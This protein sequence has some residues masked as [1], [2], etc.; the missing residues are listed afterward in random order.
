MKYIKYLIAASSLLFVLLFVSNKLM[1]KGGG[2]YITPKPSET[3]LVEEGQKLG[4]KEEW[5]EQMHRSAPDVDWQKKDFDFRLERANTEKRF[6]SRENEIYGQWAEVGSNNQAG[7]TLVAE[8]DLEESIVYVASDG[9]Q[10]WKGGLGTGNW[11]SITDHFRIPAINFIRNIHEENLDRLLIGAGVWGV[12]GIMFSD[13]GGSTWEQATGLDGIADWGYIRRVVMKNDPHEGIFL[14]SQEWDYDLWQAMSSI[15]VSYDLGESFEFLQSFP[16]G[17]NQTDIWTDRYSNGNV[18]VLDINK[19]Y[20]LTNDGNLDYIGEVATDEPER[21]YLVG[22]KEDENLSFYAM[23]YTSSLSSFYASFD[24]GE[25]WGLK[26]SLD[27][28]PFMTGSFAASPVTP[29]LLYF[30]GVDAYTSPDHGETW[31]KINSWGDYYGDPEGKL[32]ADIPSFN[33][34]INS[35]DDEI[36][37]IN[38]DGGIYLSLDD[39]ES[40]LNLSLNNLRISQYYSSYTC[41]FAPQNT[42]AGA[43]DQGYQFSDEGGA[44]EVL[45][46][47]QVI[48]G[49]YGHIVSGDEGASVWMVYPGFAMY[50]PDANSN[51]PL[52]FW[53][54]VGSNYQWMPELMADPNDP[55][56]VYIAGGN[57]SSGA[58]QIH[59]TYSNSQMTYAEEPFDFS[60]G[61]G[62]NISAMAYSTL[63]SDFRYVMTTELDFFYSVDGGDS[64][65]QTEGFD[66]PGSHYFYGADIEPSK[67]TL[68]LIYIG[69]SGYSSPGVFV[70]DD[71]GLTFSDYSEGLPETLIHDLALSADDSLLFAATEVGAYVCK[72]SEGIWYDLNDDMLPD[73]NF[74]AVDFVESLNVARFASYG[75]GIWDFDL[76]PDVVADFAADPELVEQEG[77]VQFTNLSMW[78]PTSYEW[79]FEGGTPETSDLENPGVV[80]FEPGI[81]D[82]KLIVHNNNSSDTLIKTDYIEVLPFTGIVGGETKAE[83]V[84]FPNPANEVVHIKSDIFIEQ[85]ILLDL[86]GRQLRE[87]IPGTNGLSI[88][89]KAFSKGAYIIKVK[90]EN[91]I[92]TKKIIRK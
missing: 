23:L 16:H 81:F 34:F 67:N 77:S 33:S 66:S 3:I 5:L 42:H 45:D 72:T 9:G 29:G 31:D 68:G 87:F 85:V 52:R 25:N 32:H 13:D 91:G 56:S 51:G 53:N 60:N 19:I 39:A 26:G 50:R 59:L 70:S 63:N 65:T 2:V 24:E 21:S 82:V 80:Y 15:Y 12:P 46:Y 78:N 37:F 49:D 48:S 8:L 61:T 14:A 44:G 90:T 17:A 6:T 73:Q 89:L 47:E 88:D 57:A 86:A 71:N 58:H 83:I 1:E 36:L 79:F 4:N 69:G 28:G 55:A 10:I 92:L 75:R 84:V 22:V 27:F 74:W 54:F 20:L 62:A 76:D 64:W 18:Y 40:V 35:S 41:R 43:Q 38:T 11:E 30:G 7:R